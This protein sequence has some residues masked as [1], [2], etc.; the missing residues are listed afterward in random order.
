[1]KAEV[2]VRYDYEGAMVVVVA[3]T[4]EELGRG[5]K[6]ASAFEDNFVAAGVAATTE[7]VTKARACLKRRPSDPVPYEVEL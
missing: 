5:Y 7:A 1:M 6:F 3:P 4:G 2:R